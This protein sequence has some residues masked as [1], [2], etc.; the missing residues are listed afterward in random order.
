[1]SAVPTC[2]R[3]R[4]P[5][6]AA[7]AALAACLVVCLLAQLGTLPAAA[8]TG[9]DD[10]V[11]YIP[12]NPAGTPRLFRPSVD[13]VFAVASDHGGVRGVAQQ[14]QGANATTPVLGFEFDPAPGQ[15]LTVGTYTGTIDAAEYDPGTTRP[16]MQVGTTHPCTATGTFTIRDIDLPSGRLW[17][18]YEQHCSGEDAASFGEIRL[19][20]PAQGTDLLL[21]SRELA[22]PA[23]EPG[24]PARPAPVWLVNTGTG[25]VDVSSVSV[26]AGA[27]DFT[28]QSHTC[29]VLAPGATC[30]ITLGFAPTTSGVHTGTLTVAD[31]TA[32]GT[33]AV[34][35]AGRG[36]SGTTSWS[37]HGQTNGTP[38]RAHEYEYTPANA[39]FRVGGDRHAVGVVVTPGSGPQPE[40][41]QRLVLG[42]SLNDP[43][44]ELAVGSFEDPVIDTSASPTLHV[45]TP[46]GFCSDPRGRATLHDI[47]FD[48]AGSVTRLAM[49]V[50][51]RCDDY[52][53]AIL[54]AVNW[55]AET[56]A[57]AIAPRISL[58]VD[59]P[60]AGFVAGDQAQLTVGLSRGS[61]TRTVSLYATPVGGARSL[62]WSGQV[63]VDGTDVLSYRVSRRTTFMLAF[64]GGP[65]LPSAVTSKD[66]EVRAAVTTRAL[67]FLRKD[68]R[69]HV[70]GAHQAA[71]LRSTVKPGVPGRCV[72]FAAQVF[73]AGQWQNLAGT[74]C[75]AL[76]SRDRAVVVLTASRA[77]RGRPVRVRSTFLGDDVNSYRASPWVYLRFQR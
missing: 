41:A 8:A 71:R 20:Q 75:A 2:T 22:W 73:A 12:A 7:V 3:R 17:V 21:A 64:D 63:A 13:T 23:A 70:Y 1:M 15:P 40:D 9:P 29:T 18:V 62:V 30:R 48:A 36:L 6:S 52:P 76:D 33:H 59:T 37:L 50:E 14:G 74:S 26:D 27:P 67:R 10:F 68:G 24:L 5:V 25:P 72:S 47:G 55:H 53:A 19:G 77:L 42:L 39:T 28:L 51:V 56:P 57:P 32:T 11:T 16:A 60:R 46:D 65:D 34:A 45:D 58:G 43:A 69:Y 61:S 31:S 35:L 4:G 38:L 44:T 54:G 66:V 49:T